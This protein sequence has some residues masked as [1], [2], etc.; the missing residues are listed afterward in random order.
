MRL[1][2]FTLLRPTFHGMLRTIFIPAV[3]V[4]YDYMAEVVIKSVKNGPNLVV[5]EGVTKFALCRC[6]GSNNKPFCDGT[7]ARI[8]FTA[9]EKETKVL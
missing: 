9:D 8:G 7:H 1:H 4:M 2:G 6:G 5:V 3:N